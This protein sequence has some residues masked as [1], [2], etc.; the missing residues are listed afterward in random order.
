M[1]YHRSIHRHLQRVVRSF[2]NR[3]SYSPTLWSVEIDPVSDYRICGS[4]NSGPGHYWYL[5]VVPML[6]NEVS[7]GIQDSS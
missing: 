4:P 2:V 7:V 6:P 5:G 3:H 1:D